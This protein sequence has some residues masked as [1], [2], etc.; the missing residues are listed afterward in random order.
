MDGRVE[1]QKSNDGLSY[2]IRQGDRLLKSIPINE[3]R[4]DRKLAVRHRQ[5]GW[6]EP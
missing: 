5:N 4:T 6:Q 1:G 2:E 3:A